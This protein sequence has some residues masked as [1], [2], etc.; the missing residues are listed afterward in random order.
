MNK[1]FLFLLFLYFSVQSCQA[2]QHYNID[3]M[4]KQ[5][6]KPIIVF[7]TAEYCHYCKWMKTTT[8]SKKKK[9]K[10]WQ[11]YQFLEIQDNFIGN[12]QFQGK[13]YI[14]KQNQ[15]HSFTVQYAKL[16]QRVSYPTTIIINQ[17]KEI[18]FKE[19]GFINKNT[20]LKL[21]ENL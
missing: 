3:A 13:E 21:I 1:L 12:I 4:L 19:R 9:S 6:Q 16:K 18:I 11:K 2:Q 7:F 20:F 17:E 5:N 10:L 8:F 15:V 14:A